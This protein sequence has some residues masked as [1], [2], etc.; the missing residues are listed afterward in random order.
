MKKQDET[1]GV[2]EHLPKDE[3]GR[4]L[5][6][7]WLT[8]AMNTLGNENTPYACRMRRVYI[9]LAQTFTGRFSGGVTVLSVLLG[10]DR[11]DVATALTEACKTGL[12]V[13]H[14]FDEWEII[15]PVRPEPVSLDED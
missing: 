7:F 6:L 2:W 8:H 12:L 1:V 5:N 3:R 4:V 11:E 14:G 10:M 9:A 15:R 13:H